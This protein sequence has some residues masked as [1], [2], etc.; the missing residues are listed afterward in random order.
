MVAKPSHQSDVTETPVHP[1]RWGTSAL[2][3]ATDGRLGEAEQAITSEE[4]QR[5]AV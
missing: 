5:R 4:Y 1:G 2:S 3:I